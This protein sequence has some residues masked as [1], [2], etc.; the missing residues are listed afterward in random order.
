MSSLRYRE[1]VPTTMRGI[2]RKTEGIKTRER[3]YSKGQN[4]QRMGEV[5]MQRRIN[6]KKQGGGEG[7]RKKNNINVT[8]TVESYER[9]SCV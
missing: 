8:K 4:K 2:G 6:R 3:D 9:P 7:S 1:F 5:E